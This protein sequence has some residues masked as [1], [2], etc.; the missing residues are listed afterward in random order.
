ME[1]KTRKIKGIEIAKTS[2]IVKNDKGQW[3][4]PSQTGAGFYVVQSNGFG[5]SCNCPDHELRKCKCKLLQSH[6]S[7]QCKTLL[8]IGS[9]R[10]NYCLLLIFC[11]SLL[12]LIPFASLLLF[13]VVPFLLP[14]WLFIYFYTYTYESKASI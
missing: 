1:N 12:S 5:A 2:R 3:K 4:V 9:A 7:G 13:V 11:S 6:C 8:Q 10:A 14:H